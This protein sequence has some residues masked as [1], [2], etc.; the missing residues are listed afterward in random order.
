M[1]VL[2]LVGNNVHILSSW[3]LVAL[4]VSLVLL[5]SCVALAGLRRWRRAAGMAIASSLSVTF[6]GLESVAAS[7][8][9]WEQMIAV[10]NAAEPTARSGLRRDLALYWDGT[11]EQIKLRHWA[12]LAQRW[13]VCH[14]VWPQSNCRRITAGEVGEGIAREMLSAEAK[15]AS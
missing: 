5:I 2:V 9:M 7:P 15:A 13:E 1:T 11:H 4:L 3:T 6:V 8:K 14:N 10:F 12:R